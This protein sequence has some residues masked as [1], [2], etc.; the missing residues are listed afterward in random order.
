MCAFV[1]FKNL[2]TAEFEH[3]WF[4]GFTHTFFAHGTVQGA[5]SQYVANHCLYELGHSDQLRVN[6]VPYR[7]DAGWRDMPA[8]HREELCYMKAPMAMVL[9]A[10]QFTNNDI[11]SSIWSRQLAKIPAFMIKVRS[12]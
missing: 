10:E 3:S 5:D 7:R 9:T 2:L 12:R 6:L 11:S 1:F 4:F 8:A